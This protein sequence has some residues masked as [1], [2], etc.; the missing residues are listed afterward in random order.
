MEEQLSVLQ[1]SPTPEAQTPHQKIRA[2]QPPTSRAP[3]P[4]LEVRYPS[5]RWRP[6]HTSQPSH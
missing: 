6:N 5:Y 2:L 1:I 4:K 3:V